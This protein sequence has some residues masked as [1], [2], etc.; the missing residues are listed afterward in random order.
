MSGR[1]IGARGFTIRWRPQ[2]GGPLTS[3]ICV[4]VRKKEI[5][6]A[7]QRNRVRRLVKEFFR[8]NVSRLLFPIDVVVQAGSC[9]L[10]VYS[11]IEEVMTALFKRSGIFS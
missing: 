5:K 7:V 8:L 2:L 9:K 1:R 10:F 4:I 11:E 3:R 6:K